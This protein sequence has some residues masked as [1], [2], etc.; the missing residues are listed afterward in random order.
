MLGR[1]LVFPGFRPALGHIARAFDL[2]SL[3]D[4]V[5][6]ETGRLPLRDA[7]DGNSGQGEV[8]E[9]DDIERVV[10]TSADGAGAAD[11]LDDFGFANLESDGFGDWVGVKVGFDGLG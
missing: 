3:S 1:L 10:W 11:C 2:N 9:D 5:D 7:I 6:V 8:V 4:H